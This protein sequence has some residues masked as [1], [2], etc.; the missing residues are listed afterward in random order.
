MSLTKNHDPLVTNGDIGS[1]ERITL[2]TSLTAAGGDP[3][4][5]DC[6]D[7]LPEGSQTVDIDPP[8]GLP[9]DGMFHI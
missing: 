8:D 5:I 6:I 3:D 7:R 9:V 2:R 4:Q 1:G